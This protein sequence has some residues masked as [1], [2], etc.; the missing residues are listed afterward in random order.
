[1]STPT[2]TTFKGFDAN[3]Q[4]RGFQY[5]VGQT[6][7]HDG[8]VKACGSGFHACE[9]PLNVFDY[10]PPAGSKFALVEQSGDLHRKG[11]DTKVA[12]R[13]ITIK[14]ELTIAG[15]VKAAVEYVTSR[16]EPIN[17]ESPA[18]ATGD[19]GAASAT[20][21]QGA[22]S[23]TGYQGA[24]SATGTRGAASATG[25]Q[26]AASATGENSVALAAG[27]ESRALA[28]EGGAV[29][30]VNR[31][32]GGAIHHVFASKVGD[33]GIQANTWYTL[34]ADGQPQVWEA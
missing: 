2:I 21:Y 23:A 4:C 30:L 22:A 17:P 25:Y 27:Y 28:V 33:N 8:E 6:Y 12:S 26:G 19:Q 18:A 32:S 20:G 31:D 24:A 15:L 1:M 14:A 9:H 11:D 34:G 10:Y 13:H 3:W 7:T 5:E 16:C 29:F